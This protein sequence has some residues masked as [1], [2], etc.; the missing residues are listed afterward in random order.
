MWRY[1]EIDL[2]ITIHR[3]YRSQQA[4]VRKILHIHEGLW[5]FIAIHDHGYFWEGFCKKWHI[6]LVLKKFWNFHLCFCMSLKYDYIFHTMLLHN[7]RA[8]NWV[9]SNWLIYRRLQKKHYCEDERF[10]SEICWINLLFFSLSRFKWGDYEICTES[11]GW[12]ERNRSIAWGILSVARIP[13]PPSP[14]QL[15]VSSFL[16]SRSRL[17]TPSIFH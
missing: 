17:T 4:D 7:N 16:R 8:E 5:A 1:D 3:L 10:R 13:D 2:N 11:F 15:L 9:W 6:T 12:G 14:T